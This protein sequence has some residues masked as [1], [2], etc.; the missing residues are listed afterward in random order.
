MTRSSNASIT[1]PSRR[2]SA[3]RIHVP[4]KSASSDVHLPSVRSVC[5]ARGGGSRHHD[6][7]TSG[8]HAER[9]GVVRLE[10]GPS[11]SA[12][13]LLGALGDALVRSGL[14]AESIALASGASG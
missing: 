13:E 7:I 6:G 5:R 2:A 10:L 11:D 12:Q 14:V 8:E 9:I 4:P 3:P 1:D